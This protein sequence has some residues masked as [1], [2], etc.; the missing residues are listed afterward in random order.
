MKQ[1]L[2][3]D[4]R[5][6]YNFDEPF[7]LRKIRADRSNLSTKWISL[8]KPKGYPLRQNRYGR[9]TGALGQAFAAGLASRLCHSADT[10]EEESA[11]KGGNAKKIFHWSK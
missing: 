8:K 6:L 4:S 11:L 9:Q 1:V 5:Y 2:C 7:A 3:E 10:L